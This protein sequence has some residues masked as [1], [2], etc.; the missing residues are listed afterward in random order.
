MIIVL[1][2]A[3]SA[4]LW[5]LLWGLDVKAL[6]ALLVCLVIMI[7]ASVAHI[8]LPYLPGNRANRRPEPDPAP[9]N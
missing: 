5:V 8:M 7:L 1:A 3:F 9:Y 6:D 2:A 4:A